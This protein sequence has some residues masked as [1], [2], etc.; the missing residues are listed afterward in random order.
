MKPSG[1]AAR[2]KSCS[3]GASVAPAQPRIIALVGVMALG[4]DDDAAYIAA[5]ELAAYALGGGAVAHR[6][7]LDAVINAALPEIG[8]RPGG[9][10]PGEQVAVGLADLVPFLAAGLLA[11]QGTELQA[12][13]A[14]GRRR[15]P[16]RRRRD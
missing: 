15:G 8:A 11:A 4:T 1:S 16:C 3:A 6:G 2:K 13:A 10:E 7:S 5:L 9:G 14:A 12:I